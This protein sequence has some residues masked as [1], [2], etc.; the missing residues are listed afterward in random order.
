MKIVSWLFGREEFIKHFKKYARDFAPQ[1]RS[2]FNSL[3]FHNLA[4]PFLKRKFIKKSIASP[5]PKAPSSPDGASSFNE[6]QFKRVWI[7][8]VEH[9]SS[10]DIS[11]LIDLFEDY[12]SITYLICIFTPQNFCSNLAKKS[13]FYLIKKDSWNEVIRK[14]QEIYIV[15]ERMGSKVP[16]FWNNFTKRE[17]EILR[18][19]WKNRERYVSLEEISSY[20]YGRRL[21]NNLHSSEVIISILR[22]KLKNLVEKNILL[23]S[24]NLGYILDFS[25][26]DSINTRKA[27]RIKS[28]GK[29]LGENMGVS[30]KECKLNHNIEKA[31]AKFH[32]SKELKEFLIFVGS[33]KTGSIPQIKS[34]DQVKKPNKPVSLAISK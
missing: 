15:I 10:M 30:K 23:Y 2:V 17:K 7:L 11:K 5:A 20:L 8:E 26:L 9:L 22:K 28:K 33:F 31:A 19:L 32:S 6:A 3:S 13:D 34:N 16:Y 4:D 24:R 12:S 25:L 29:I 27:K 14:I 18:I 1:Y 21:R